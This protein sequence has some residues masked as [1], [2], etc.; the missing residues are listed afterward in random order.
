MGLNLKS[1]DYTM[2]AKSKPWGYKPDDVE[3]AIREHRNTIGLLNDKVIEQKQIIINQQ[4]K[5]KKLQE[6]LRRMHLEMSSLEL[7]AVDQ[8]VED[9]VLGNFAKYNEVT[10]ITHAQN[11][12]D[13]KEFQE[14]GPEIV[15]NYSSNNSSNDHSNKDSEDEFIIVT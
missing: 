13:N 5:I 4:D 8:A 15:G 2:F 12:E 6:E 9:M 11:E 14:H 1:R 3:A 7:P 10:Q